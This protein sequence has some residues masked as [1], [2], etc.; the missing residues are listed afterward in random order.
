M[1]DFPHPLRL[2]VGSHQRGTGKGCAMNVI[3]YENGDAEITDTPGCSD[4]MLT[5]VAQRVNDTYCTHR[6][7][8]LLCAPCSVE[9]LHVAHRTVGTRLD[10]P[11]R[12]VTRL[13]VTLAAEAAEAAAPPKLT[14]VDRD[15]LRLVRAWLD[16]TSV[17]EGDLHRASRCAVWGPAQSASKAVAYAVPGRPDFYGLVASSAA[18]AF[19]HGRSGVVTPVVAHRVVDRFEELTCVHQ[20]TAASVAAGVGA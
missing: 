9:V 6:D 4:L 13:Y 12:E 7:E 8:D 15:A 5:F 19:A 11:L 10:W 18:D 3:S 17:S 2:A 16:G 1:N 14:Q 20:S